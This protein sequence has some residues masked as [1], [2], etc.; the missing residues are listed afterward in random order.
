[1]LVVA[2]LLI[3]TSAMRSPLKYRLPMMLRA[4]PPI[5]DPYDTFT[6]ADKV[7]FSLFSA[8]VNAEMGRNDTLSPKNYSELMALINE[9]TTTRRKEQVHAQATHMLVRLFPSWL[10]PA[11]Q[12]MFARP[13]PR[14][15]AW[16]NAWVTHW[17]TNWLMGPS[18]VYDLSL[19]DGTIGT[20]QGLLVRP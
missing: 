17:T 11:Y 7:L 5:A 20:Q 18:A 14:F 15:S 2:I 4:S 10:L 16:M 9:M 1:M 19:P 6:F 12:V 8:S 13:F 3:M